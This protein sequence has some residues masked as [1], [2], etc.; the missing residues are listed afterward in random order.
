M[1]LASLGLDTPKQDPTKLGWH[2]VEGCPA[3]GFGGSPEFNRTVLE[4]PHTSAMTTMFIVLFAWTF[5]FW[6]T[7]RHVPLL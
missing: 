2:L 3:Y 4:A 5:C 1:R 7:H 6:Q